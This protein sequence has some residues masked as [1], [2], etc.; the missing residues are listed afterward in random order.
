MTRPYES[1]W[2][3]LCEEFRRLD[4]M[5]YRQ[6]L[7]HGSAEESAQ[8]EVD[9][10]RGTVGL[11]STSQQILTYLRQHIGYSSTA[12]KD[13][14]GATALAGSVREKSG[15]I[16]E[17]LQATREAGRLLS[18]PTLQTVFRLNDF[19]RHCL[20]AGLAPSP[21]LLAIH[22]P[23]KFGEQFAYLQR[24]AACRLPLINTLVRLFADGD[25][26]AGEDFQTAFDR[27]GKLARYR[28]LEVL[29]A[30]EP[31]LDRVVR[32]DDWMAEFMLGSGI[33]GV[34]QRLEES[35][36]LLDH[37]R[38]SGAPAD[39]S[40]RVA[41]F[42]DDSVSNGKQLLVQ[43]TG[44]RGSSKQCLA[45]AAVRAVKFP[46]LV[47][48]CARLVSG[49]V[50]PIDA[51]WLLGREALLRPAAIYLSNWDRAMDEVSHREAFL[52]ELISAIE[53]LCHLVFID[54]E[55]SVRLPRRPS[56]VRC[57]HIAV[58][59]PDLSQRRDLWQ[60][61]YQHKTIRWDANC[62][63]IDASE[64][65]SKFRFTA[66]QIDSAIQ[67]AN[68]NALWI[69]PTDQTVKPDRKSVV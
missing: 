24:N 50:S 49:N 28:L 3:Y 64:L 20:I 60:W 31:I 25:E 27:S 54:S 30:P 46:L 33:C 4:L 45:S 23:H 58:P 2:E 17:R 6:I 55:R 51:I 15:E 44:Q 43:L 1:D 53:S 29:E 68:D 57:V 67:R 19:E 11:V 39:L 36:E 16:E 61:Q 22:A 14:K 37:P 41:A 21:R 62:K 66:N 35:V 34:D 5:I 63:P 9:Q 7:R 10:I 52:E 32:V 8:A 65:A 48:D 59:A 56:N 47:V 69:S 18:L 42:V 13:S 12:V 38:L 26:A 40:E